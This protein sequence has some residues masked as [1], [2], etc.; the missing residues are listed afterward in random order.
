[1]NEKFYVDVPININNINKKLFMG[2]TA[3]QIIGF[4]IVLVI[5]IPLYSSLKSI[6]PDLA[7]AISFLVTV[8]IFLFVFYKK[9]NL[10][11]EKLLK[12]YLE[13][14]FIYN[15]T[16]KFKIGRKNKEIAKKRGLLK[17]EPI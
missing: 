5:F 6:S 10:K 3:R 16:R 7:I 1:M 12:V 17:D 11:S 2:L 15:K 8:P 13:Y 4:I 14:K 9:D